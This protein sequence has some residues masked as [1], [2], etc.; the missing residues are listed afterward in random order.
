MSDV[1]IV[2][3][4]VSDWQTM[5]GCAAI[6]KTLEVGYE[7]RIISAHRTPE[8]LHAYGK[9]L[10]KRG[11]KVVIAGAGGAA[12]LPG[13]MASYS[14]LPVLG[15]PMKTSFQDGLDSLLSIVN[16][17]SGVGVGTFAVGSSGAV[18][19][20]LFAA[21]ILSLA[22]AALRRRLIAWR[23]EQTASVPDTPE[24]V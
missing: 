21:A 8:R 3:G 19:A 24:D 2:M 13:M 12:H 22:D 17:P 14:H 18:N 16:M 5:R 7:V 23:A 9:G 20:G 15:V 1:A 10:V 6:L 4:S 11:I